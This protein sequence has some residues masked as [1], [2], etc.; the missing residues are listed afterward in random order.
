MRTLCRDNSSSSVAVARTEL[1]KK[2][3][4]CV[5]SRGKVEGLGLGQGVPEP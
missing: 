3:F 2:I 4:R 1:I 5:Q